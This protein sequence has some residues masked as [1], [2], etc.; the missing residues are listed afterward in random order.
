MQLSELRDKAST[1]PQSPGVYI[2]RDESGGVIYVGKAIKLQ[3]RVKQYFTRLSSHTPKTLKMVSK[4]SDFDVINAP[5]ELDALLLENNLI[6]KY[7]PKYNIL[8]KDDKGYPFIKL[9][10]GPYPGFSVE[11]RRGGKGK[12]FGPFGGRGTANAAVRAVNEIFMLPTCG[13][14]FPRDIGKERPCL[15]YHLHKCCGVCTGNVSE[16][17]F[18][19]M[20][21]RAVR[22]FEGRTAE[23]EK[24]LAADM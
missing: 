1:L 24:Q 18:D 16:A 2:M 15:R 12:Y 22:L 7:K 10:D 6:K 23:L 11:S 3:N 5:S 21:G 19:G 9:A 20:I 4:V 8:L 17:E 14:K 13:K